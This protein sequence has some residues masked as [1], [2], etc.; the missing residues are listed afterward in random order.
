MPTHAKK[1]TEQI[2]TQRA[3]RALQQFQSHHRTPTNITSS[4]LCWTCVNA[5]PSTEAGTGCEW[6]RFLEPVPGWE[7]KKV[8]S[9]SGLDGTTYSISECPKYKPDPPRAFVS[10]SV[11][12]EGD[13]PRFREDGSYV[14]Y[15]YNDTLKEYVPKIGPKEVSLKKPAQAYPSWMKGANTALQKLELTEQQSETLNTNMH[16]LGTLP[17]STVKELIDR[18]TS[19]SAT[20]LQRYCRKYGKDGWY[21][22]MKRGRTGHVASPDDVCPACDGKRYVIKP[23]GS[24]HVVMRCPKCSIDLTDTLA[25]IMAYAD[26]VNFDHKKY[27][28]Y[29]N[30]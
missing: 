6:S 3:T 4:Q 22:N 10:S 25:A 1:T 12:P 18:E 15:V 8:K 23:Y 21:L 26:G 29:I 14:P 27:P 13:V 2:K 17:T 9:G 5:V 7:A 24:R 30:K 19:K 28:F 20:D 16:I 11:A